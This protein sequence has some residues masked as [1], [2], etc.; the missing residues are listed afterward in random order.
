MQLAKIDR[1]LYFC[2]TFT[3]SEAAVIKYLQTAPIDE[4]DK[5]LAVITKRMSGR[6]S[7]VVSAAERLAIAR[8][9]DEAW[10]DYKAGNYCTSDEVFSRMH[11][12]FAEAK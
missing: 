12:V 10:A 9:I 6:R 8:E 7:K 3:M 2:Y 5:Y 4:L 11:K 1:S